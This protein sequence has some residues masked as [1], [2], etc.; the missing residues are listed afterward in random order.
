MLKSHY[1]L[2]KALYCDSGV[3]LL[4]ILPYLK[5]INYDNIGKIYKG[6]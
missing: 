3:N 5:I 6:L 2:N 4:I 1:D